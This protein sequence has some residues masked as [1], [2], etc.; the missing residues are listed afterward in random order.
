MKWRGLRLSAEV[1]S[2]RG[3]STGQTLGSVTGSIWSNVQATHR[4]VLRIAS[5][6]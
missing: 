1:G 3:E 6:P 4:P 2:D 5:A